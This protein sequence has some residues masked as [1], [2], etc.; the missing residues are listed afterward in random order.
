MSF[1]EEKPRKVT[2][3][4]IITSSFSFHLHQTPCQTIVVTMDYQLA[5]V[6]LM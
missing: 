6:V 2:G 3:S 5:K 1:A 4:T